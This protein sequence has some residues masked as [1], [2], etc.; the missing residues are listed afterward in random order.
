[1]NP[2]P[3]PKRTP[4]PKP[5]LMSPIPALQTFFAYLP[6]NPTTPKPLNPEMNPETLN[7]KPKPKPKM[8]NPN[9]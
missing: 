6:L 9:P 7:P 5:K 1:M 2:E 3:L 8:L 4:K